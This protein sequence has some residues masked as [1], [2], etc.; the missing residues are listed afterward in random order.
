MEYFIE[1]LIVFGLGWYLGHK[2][3][4]AIHLRLFKLILSDLNITNQ[5][6]VNMARKHGAEFIT[7]EIDAKFKEMEDDGLEQIDIKVE[8]H[9]DTLYAFRKDNDQFLGQGSSREDLIAALEERMTNVRLIVVEG[10]EHMK[11]EAS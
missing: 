2:L 7:P 8:K 11:S 10:H 9:S 1:L 5:D 3:S 6:L 4:A